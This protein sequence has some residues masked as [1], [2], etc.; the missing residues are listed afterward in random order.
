MRRLIRIAALLL[1]ALLTPLT[2]L[3]RPD[4]PARAEARRV[5]S[6]YPGHTDNIVALGLASSLV[7]ISQHDAP[8]IRPD[9]PRLP[10]KTGAEAILALTPDVVLMRSLN[11]RLNPALQSTLERADIRVHI[12]EPPSWDE[13]SDYLAQLAAALGSSPEDARAHLRRVLEDA[14]RT[15]ADDTARPKVFLE[16]T[17][18]E[19]HTCAPNSWAAALIEL[20]GGSNAA[21][22]AHPLRPGSPLAAWG[23]ERTIQTL[24]SGL[25]VYLVQQGAM[26]ATTPETLR[27]R[28]WAQVFGPTPIAF[29]PERFLSRPTLLSLEQGI[30]LLRAA[31]RPRGEPRR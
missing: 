12:L 11:A 16:A 9:I 21:A 17:A 26:N 18:K 28:P 3:V 19:L 6:L 24:A 1:L 29:V 10:A 4:T 22:D 25:D 2:P 7:G 13:F 31:F 15:A 27:A 8:D 20:A 23:V 30:P 5:V 14:R